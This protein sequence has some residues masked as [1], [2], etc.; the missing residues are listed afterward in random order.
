MTDF[1]KFNFQFTLKIKPIVE[2]EIRK[3]KKVWIVDG[4]HLLTCIAAVL[5]LHCR[6]LPPL[7][8]PKT[9]KQDA[10]IWEGLL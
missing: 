9:N 1:N 4:T 3:K 8:I 2:N 10:I 5:K 6:C 7:E